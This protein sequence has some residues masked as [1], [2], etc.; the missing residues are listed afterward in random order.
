MLA[1]ALQALGDPNDAGAAGT[2]QEQDQPQG[3]AQQAQGQSEQPAPGPEEQDQQPQDATAAQIL[4][5]ERRDRAAREQLQRG[6]L[7]RTPPVEKN[8]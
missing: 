2:P 8:W 1:E 3:D 6:T 4:D 7:S 5:K